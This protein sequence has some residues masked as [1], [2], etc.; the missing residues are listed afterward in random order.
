MQTTHILSVIIMLVLMWYT[1][2]KHF[3]T[4]KNK[5]KM[6]ESVNFVVAD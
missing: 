1:S 2:E 6:V 5:K 3:N 4:A